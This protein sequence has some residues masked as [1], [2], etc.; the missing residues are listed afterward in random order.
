MGTQIGVG[1][2]YHRN[3]AIAGKEAATRALQ[4]AQ[5]TAAE[6]PDFVMLFAT[7]GYRQPLLLQAVR[8]ATHQAPLVGCS[9]AG[10]IAQG[11]A[12]E[13]N[14]S[15]TVML[16]KSDEMHFT[17]GI[18]TGIKASSAQVGEAV[19]EAISRSVSQD[20]V[21]PTEAKALFLFLEGISS[22]FDEFIEALRQR[23]NLEKTIPAIGGFAGDDLSMRETFQYC[24]DRITT[25][26]AVWALLS[27]EVKV[28]SVMSH[29]CISVGERHTIT[30]C[31]RNMIIEID[32]QPAIEVIQGYLSQAE[33]K[34]WNI[35]VAMLCLAFDSA[36][37]AN[38]EA[39]AKEIY[40][41]PDATMIRSIAAIDE[42]SGAIYMMSDMAKGSHF[43]VAR[44]DHE[45][46]CDKSEQMADAL[47]SQLKLELDETAS[48]KLIFHVECVGRGKLILREAEKLALI[49]QLQSKM[50]QKIPWVGFYANAEI[51]PMLGHNYVHNFT[52]ILTA[53]Y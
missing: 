30:K 4:Q 1:V 36:Y 5:L 21:Q 22:N 7:I 23:T 18:E 11:I 3:P 43:S 14:F 12:D 25:D 49:K 48:P 19:G 51:G 32:H 26:G 35:A 17:Y 27:G 46:I 6:R 15:V 29:G 38:E 33:K 16:I 10:V 45:K 20:K 42:Q 13:S 39:V 8:A 40:I 53:F 50:G 44:R 31:D 52:S 28:A 24:D 9:G 41:D 2:S 34:D 37:A 47:L